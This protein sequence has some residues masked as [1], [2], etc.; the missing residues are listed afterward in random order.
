MTLACVVLA[1]LELIGQKQERNA[2]GVSKCGERELPLAVYC[3]VRVSVEA[4]L[5][6]NL[7]DAII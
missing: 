3:R 1:L 2:S 5:E 4:I 7:L 6:L